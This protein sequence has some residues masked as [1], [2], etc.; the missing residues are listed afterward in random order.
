MLEQDKTSNIKHQTSNIGHRTSDISTFSPLI[1][2][3]SLP[4]NSIHNHNFIVV[5]LYFDEPAIIATGFFNTVINKQFTAFLDILLA[6]CSNDRLG[7]SG[8]LQGSI[9][10]IKHLIIKGII[11]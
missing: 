10:L 9:S 7:Q 4:G 1:S 8:E 2:P 6:L 3:L 11:Q 5:T